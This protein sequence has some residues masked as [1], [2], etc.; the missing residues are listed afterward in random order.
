MSKKTKKT[1]TKSRKK[2]VLLPSSTAFPSYFVDAIG[3]QLSKS[4]RKRVAGKSVDYWA[5]RLQRTKK[6]PRS[7]EER[8]LLLTAIYGRKSNYTNVILTE[9]KVKVGKAVK[10]EVVVDLNGY[11]PSAN[12]F[13]TIVLELRDYLKDYELTRRFYGFV[14]TVIEIEWRDLLT[15]SQVITYMSSGIVRGNGKTLEKYVAEL[16]ASDILEAINWSDLGVVGSGLD[17]Q[18]QFES[19]VSLTIATY[20]GKKDDN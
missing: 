3:K 9:P 20:K 12:N 11:E 4:D 19:V 5:E 13:S 1:H 7:K 15:G 6:M 14:K 2:K 16:A 10:G 18:S 17:N 8:R